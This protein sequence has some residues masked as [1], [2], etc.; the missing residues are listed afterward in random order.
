MFSA[1]REVCGRPERLPSSTLSVPSL[2]R[3]CLSKA[4]VRD[5]ISQ[6][7]TCF[8]ISFVSDD[9]DNII[10]QL[11]GAPPHRSANVPDYLD[12]HLPHWWIRRVNDYNVRLTQWPPRSPDLTFCDFLLWGFVKD[13]VFVP[14]LP[15]DLADLKQRITTVIDGLDSD[16][17]TRVS[18]EV[19]NR[20]NVCRM[21]KGSRVD[22]L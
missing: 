15:V 8:K 17:L 5:N 22:H 2:K 9:I 4:P 3:R 1:V 13:K 18:V 14:N 16:I 19:D 7:Y 10:L 20:L 12:E 6:P 11:E 21:I